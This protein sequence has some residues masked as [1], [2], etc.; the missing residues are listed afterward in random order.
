MN[1]VLPKE[2]PKS[3]EEKQDLLC[4]LS[5]CSIHFDAKIG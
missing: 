4:P 3:E 1:V 2:I 5:E